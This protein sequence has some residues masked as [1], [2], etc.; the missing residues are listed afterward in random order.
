MAGAAEKIASLRNRN[1]RALASMEEYEDLVAEQ[2]AQ[3]GKMNRPSG[4]TF[5]DD[6]GGDETTAR[7]IDL[8][9]GYPTHS[10]NTEE[11]LRRDEQTCAELEQK[12]RMLEERV[13]GMEK[14][15]GGLMR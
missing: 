12:K 7:D 13:S 11:A 3:L 4:L 10:L 5:D 15:L 9:E 6:E 2:T 1:A 14:D 8:S